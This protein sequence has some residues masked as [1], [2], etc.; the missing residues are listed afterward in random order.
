MAILK[1]RQL[2][3]YNGCN[4]GHATPAKWIYGRHSGFGEA[5]K[6]DT[7]HEAGGHTHALT[8][9]SIGGDVA[10]GR[11]SDP[12]GRDRPYSPLDGAEL[13]ATHFAGLVSNGLGP[14]ETQLPLKQPLDQILDCPARDC[15]PIK[16][17]E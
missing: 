2:V 3:R 17:A 13:P 16:C 15:R 9:A 11:L 7:L 10:F 4:L 14:L 12:A 8:P 6:A 1:V 5:S